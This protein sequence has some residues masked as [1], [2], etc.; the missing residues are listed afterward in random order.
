MFKIRRVTM[1]FGASLLPCYNPC[2]TDV[3]KAHL[4]FGVTLKTEDDSLVGMNPPYLE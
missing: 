2:K 4:S 3:L 1:R